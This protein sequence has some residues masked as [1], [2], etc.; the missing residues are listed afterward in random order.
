V[1]GETLPRG[2]AAPGR[3]FD[4]PQR[5]GGPAAFLVLGL[6]GVRDARGAQHR[7][8]LREHRPFRLLEPG[9]P[10][11]QR[12]QRVAEVAQQLAV[13]H[14][15][16]VRARDGVEAGVA[17]PGG[18]RGGGVVD[19]VG[20]PAHVEDAGHRRAV[21]HDQPGLEVARG[22]HDADAVHVGEAAQRGRLVRHAV[23]EAHDRCVLGGVGRD[24][25]YDVFGVHALDPEH[26]DVAGTPVDL[27]RVGGR[28]E[29]ERALPVRRA[30]R[31]TTGAD[32]V[33]VGATRHQH[34]VVARPG[35]VSADHSTDRA[36]SDDH[37][38][39]HRDDTGARSRSAW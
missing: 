1:P 15:H 26:G 32:R 9:R 17:Q 10:A 39:H 4:R 22:K 30:H 13:L 31:E 34:H 6:R 3:A 8:A 24:G 2:P 23:L 38:S 37:P 21:R 12:V 28:R 11:A 16:D 36:R 5:H 7:L 27:G 14:A 25:A 20:E 18:H 19:A 35:Q 33:E 29:P